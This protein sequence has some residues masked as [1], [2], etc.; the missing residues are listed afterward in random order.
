MAYRGTAGQGT[1]L[2]RARQ[3][4]QKGR[5]EACKY[6]IKYLLCRLYADSLCMLHKRVSKIPGPVFLPFVQ[7]VQFPAVLAQADGLQVFLPIYRSR[8]SAQEAEPPQVRGTGPGGQTAGPGT[9]DRQMA[10]QRAVSTNKH[11]PSMH[12]GLCDHIE[13]QFTQPPVALLPTG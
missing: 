8:R 12:I 1:G 4:A 9:E 6:A 10:G 7:S 2:Q 13:R 3:S 11:L 5:G